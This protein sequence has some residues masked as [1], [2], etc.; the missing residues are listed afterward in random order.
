M[1][2][3]DYLC[4]FGNI[5]LICI[6]LTKTVSLDGIC[7]N[8]NECTD[9][10]PIC[11]N[12][13]CQCDTPWYTPCGTKCDI[14]AVFVYEGEECRINDNCIPNAV[15]ADVEKRCRCQSSYTA[16]NGLCYKSL[17][18]SCSTP[19]ECWS[20]DCRDG[21]CKCRLGFVPRGDN[22][23]CQRKL[24]R[25]Y[26]NWAEANAS[27][28]LCYESNENPCIDIHAICQND[29]Q[30]VEK[31]CQCPLNYTANYQNQECQLKQYSGSLSPSTTSL[32]NDDCGTCRDELA[33]C[34]HV[35]NQTTCWC[36]AG[37]INTNDRCERYHL[38]FVFP[39]EYDINQ[40][41]YTLN[42]SSYDNDTKIVQNGLCICKPGYK[43]VDARSPCQRII[44][45]W[46]N[47]N[48][49][50][51]VCTRID[52]NGQHIP[53]NGLCPWPLTCQPRQD[54]Y[55]CSC[56]HNK[57]LDENN[58]TCYYFLER[59][60]TNPN[61]KNCPPG[62]TLD[63]GQCRCLPIGKYT[64]SSD[65]KRCELT[66]ASRDID[67]GCISNGG[68]DDDC[69]RLYGTN[70]K[71]CK[72][73]ECQCIPDQSYYDNGRCVTYLSAN[74]GNNGS[75][76]IN[77]KDNV[78][79]C[80]CK[81]GYRAESNN[82]TCQRKSNYLYE[83]TNIPSQ[84]IY[85]DVIIDDCKALYLNAHLIVRNNA[86]ICENG[87]FSNGTT[88][89]FYLSFTPL[90]TNGASLHCPPLALPSSGACTCLSGYKN[91]GNDRNCVPLTDTVYE[92]GTTNGVNVPGLTTT[93]CRRLFGNAVD[94]IPN[95][96]YCRCANS[97]FAFWENQR[98][99]FLVETNQSMSTTLD[100]CPPTSIVGNQTC[101]CPR[102]YQPIESKRRCV[103]KPIYSS[104]LQAIDT[105]N[106]TMLCNETYTNDDCEGLHGKGAVCHNFTC[107]C[108]RARSF[109]VGDRCEYFS[110]FVFPGLHERYSRTCNR[111][112]DCG[113]DSDQNGIE[114]DFI[115]NT[116]DK[117]RVCKCKP[118]YFLNPIDGTCV[119]RQCY[120]Q[121]SDN[122]DCVNYQC[123]CRVGYYRNSSGHC[124]LIGT[125]L[126]LHEKC[127]STVWSGLNSINN[128]LFCSST[129]ERTQCAAGYRDTGLQ[130]ARISFNDYCVHSK[131]RCTQ[132]SPNSLCQEDDNKC[133]C[134]PGHYE[135]NGNIIC[136]R[137]INSPCLKH[138]DCG[139]LGQCLGSRCRC[140]PGNREQETS[141]LYGRRIIRCVNGND[142]F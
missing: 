14:K 37:L 109:V 128:G 75:C 104:N 85:S 27:N 135:T 63:N 84:G 46:E 113:S 142:S 66:L 141:D 5:L 65:K 1:L 82:R 48:F 33:V 102:G 95:D 136:A 94:T 24:A 110:Q 92:Y 20:R 116:T 9:I 123:I 52:S 72:A 55:V 108:D 47:D 133:A 130:C 89:V 41:Q 91:A 31:F 106:F 12:G 120:P 112:E 26:S 58:N 7:T 70:T 68:F 115:N 140:R 16:L 117:Y 111:Q 21:L 2:S 40:H 53:E 69:K 137:A 129:C 30:H 107:Y 134:L 43:F 36:Q 62:A 17:N 122:A 8:T 97:S 56:D 77:T 4:L 83:L 93:G 76:P 138:A 74:P 13:R 81:D 87:T 39:N 28:D 79:P 44:P 15:C 125:P 119:K 6:S 127:N 131:T 18:T 51:G 34:V 139:D 100:N 59:D 32:P 98:C 73:G 54:K 90:P 86:C 35:G 101:N 61:D 88:C 121:C 45:I 80:T 132:F 99:Y 57:Y 38:N 23:R 49:E 64:V 124:D 118:E 78:N 103:R 96:S 10:G 42:C 105:T 22:N 50:Y 67:S 3:L 29:G 25:I 71:F 114:C 126:I 11:R 60:L 19:S